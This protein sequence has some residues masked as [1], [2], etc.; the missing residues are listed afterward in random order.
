MRASRG[1]QRERVGNALVEFLR[2]ERGAIELVEHLAVLD[3]EHA[4][5]AAGRAQGMRDH[6]DGLPLSVHGFEQAHQLVRRAGIQRAGGLVGQQQLRIGDQRAGDGHA[7]FLAAGYFIGEFF[8][9]RFNAQ[10]ARERCEP[11]AH[12]RKA[13]ARKHQRQK[14]VVLQ[15]ERIQQIEILEHKAQVVP[16]E[17]GLFPAAQQRKRPAVELHLAAGG[18]IQ[19]GQDVE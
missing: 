6:H 18:F 15:R 19:R 3:E 9:Q 8:Q 12:L 10:L 4:P 2:G 5:G 11:R 17:G 16:A 7:L 14:N 13:H 1:D